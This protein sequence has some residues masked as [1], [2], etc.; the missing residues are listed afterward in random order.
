MPIFTYIFLL[1]SVTK[2]ALAKAQRLV[3]ALAVL[4]LQ[5]NEKLKNYPPKLLPNCNIEDR[6][7][8]KQIQCRSGLFE[9]FLTIANDYNK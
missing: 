1:S 7:P 4:I 6:A 8:E 5:F 2:F 9:L 3:I